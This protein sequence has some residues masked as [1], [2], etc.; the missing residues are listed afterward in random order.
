MATRAELGFVAGA[1]GLAAG[2]YVL[3]QVSNYNLTRS[4]AFQR[5]KGL[6]GAKGI[7]NI[8][9]GCKWNHRA[10]ARCQDPA[11]TVNVDIECPECPKTTLA[12]LE[13][14]ALPFGTKQFGVAFASH[15]LEHL[16]NWRAALTEWN[17][18]ADRVIVVLP[19]PSF[20]EKRNPLHKQHFGWDI[21]DSIEAGWPNTEVYLTYGRLA[22]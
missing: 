20:Y 17:R 12:D 10:E 1:A 3:S 2:L 21:M 14:A 22:A 16:D 7:I 8:G 19:R 4:L 15:V 11:V 13:S 5:A 18:V 9:S 6:A